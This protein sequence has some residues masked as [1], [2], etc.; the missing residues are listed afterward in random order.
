MTEV[1]HSEAHDGAPGERLNWLR[2]A[3]LGAN[4]GIVSTA[5]LVVGVAGTTN[6][7]S[8]L[9]TAGLPGLLAGA[10]SMAFLAR[11]VDRGSARPSRCL[12]R[13]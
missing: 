8:A 7:R 9:L 2:A 11:G 6:D 3:V 10:M 5:G 1:T 13:R 12:G 4:G